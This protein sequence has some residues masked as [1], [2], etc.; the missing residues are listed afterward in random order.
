ME[1]IRK[2][3]LKDLD[4]LLELWERFMKHQRELGKEYGEDR[5][6]RMRKDAK[7]IV[8]SYFEKTIRSPNGLLIVYEEDSV[9]QG[10]ML[11][12]INKNIP[13]FNDPEV[14]YISDIYLEFEF[15]GR[16]IGRKLFERTMNWF[17]S[18]GVKEV[19]IKVLHYN[20]IALARYEGWGFRRDYTDLS[21]K[22]D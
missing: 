3:K 6:P 1:I 8:R 16:G 12:N 17:D 4:V 10:Y 20:D 2:A 19:S 21:L 15:R 18:K 22:F 13:I 14:G 5:V 11:S 7:D 9:I